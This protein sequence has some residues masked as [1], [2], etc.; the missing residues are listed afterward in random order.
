M[1]EWKVWKQKRGALVRCEKKKENKTETKV[2]RSYELHHFHGPHKRFL[3]WFVCSSCTEDCFQFFISTSCAGSTVDLSFAL[4]QNTKTNNNNYFN[5]HD[6]FIFHFFSFHITLTSTK[7]YVV[8]FIFHLL[9]I[10]PLLLLLLLIFIL[11]LLL[12]ISIPLTFL[13]LL[14][15]LE[16]RKNKY[17]QQ[18]F[19]NT[20]KNNNNIRFSFCVRAYTTCV[21][22]LLA[23]FNSLINVY[24]S[25]INKQNEL[26]L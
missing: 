13:Y 22:F 4:Y 14:N 24:I 17:R 5:W 15:I 18:H 21:P 2:H 25:K 8:A 12:S 26:K 7:L 6:D 20:Q 10:F 19:S 9:A 1:G 11:F 3:I 16:C 23:F